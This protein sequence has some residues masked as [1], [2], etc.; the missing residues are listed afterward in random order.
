[1]HAAPGCRRRAW[2]L[3]GQE[4]HACAQAEPALRSQVPDAGALP[5]QPVEVISFPAAMILT[6]PVHPRF[7][8]CAE[9]SL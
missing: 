9:T 2:Q 5:R 4:P 1:M 7:I 3:R 6:V 8:K